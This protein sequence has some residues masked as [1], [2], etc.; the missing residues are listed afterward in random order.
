MPPSQTEVLMATAPTP[1]ATRKPVPR[2][3]PVVFDWEGKTYEYDPYL[4]TVQQAVAIK[5]HT[6]LGLK[7]W[8]AAVD[9]WDAAAVQALLWVIK[10]QNGETCPIT[11]IEL[12]VIEFMEAYLPEITRAMLEV[13]EQMEGDDEDPSEAEAATGDL[14]PISAS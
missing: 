3:K 10:G 13:F 9:D 6:G 5:L 11:S 8:G 12:N 14:T 2:M 7:S 1:G 4:I